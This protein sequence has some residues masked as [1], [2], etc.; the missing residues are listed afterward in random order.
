MASSPSP[1][2]YGMRG[3]TC[4]ITSGVVAMTSTLAPTLTPRLT[5]PSGPGGLTCTSITSTA[6]GEPGPNS[7]P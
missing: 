7:P 5:R 2:V 4:A 6:K 3:L 1:K